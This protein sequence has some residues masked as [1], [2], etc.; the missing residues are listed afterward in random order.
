[1]NIRGLA[2]LAA[3]F[4]VAVSAHAETSSG[5]EIS[6]IVPEFCQIESSVV[7]VDTD[8]MSVSGTV[9]EMCNSGRGFRIIATHRSL[10]AGEKVQIKYGGE[11]RQLDSSGVSNVAHRYGPIARDVPVEIEAN[12][13]VQGLSVSLGLAVF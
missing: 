9:L 3:A 10:V 6:L 5:A 1:M 11:I 4:I 8:N 2:I 12:G 7:A 13:L